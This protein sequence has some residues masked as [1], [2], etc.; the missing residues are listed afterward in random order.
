MRL[1]WGG[2]EIRGG[3]ALRLPQLNGTI[4]R[5]RLPSAQEPSRAP[6]FPFT[7]IHN[8]VKK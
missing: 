2:L 7:F 3:V 5:A 8:G 4:E 1:P 6:Q